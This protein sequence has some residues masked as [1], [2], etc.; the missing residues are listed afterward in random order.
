MGAPAFSSEVATIA[1]TPIAVSASNWT[2][3]NLTVAAAEHSTFA[4]K[5]IFLNLD[6]EC[7]VD[8]LRF[9]PAA[10]HTAAAIKTDDVLL[11]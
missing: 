2:L 1:V 7:F 9:L 3:L 6:G 4:G 8:W 5:T 11:R 10:E